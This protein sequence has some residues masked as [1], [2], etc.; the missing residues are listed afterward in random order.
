MNPIPTILADF[1]RQHPIPLWRRALWFS[2]AYFVFAW[3]GYFVSVHQSTFVCFWLA[4]GLFLAVLLLSR[5]RDW[6]WLVLAVLPANALFEILHGTKLINIP[7]FYFANTVQAVV[8]A[9]LI[10]RF[11]TPKPSLATLK[12]FLG[13][14]IF[15]AVLSPMLGATIGAA[16]LTLSGLSN[17]FWQSWQI[18]WGTNAMSALILTPF[19][20]AWLTKST[21]QP[22]DGSPKRDGWRRV[23]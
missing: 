12:E 19:V 21:E 11:I 14:L 6:F 2:V 17:S 1:S 16:T 18:W 5:M 8:G 22:V 7:F 4:D 23:Y 20:M 15:G 9:W 13:I 3:T 10:R